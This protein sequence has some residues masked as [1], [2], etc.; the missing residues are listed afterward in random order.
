MASQTLD[1]KAFS[2]R[3]ILHLVHDHMGGPDGWAKT[4]EMA[5]S[6]GLS[7]NGMDKAAFDRH[8]RQCL[9]IR[10]SWIRRLTGCVER[11]MQN[12][13]QWR[14]TPDGELVVRAKLSG[15][16]ANGLEQMGDQAALLALQRLSA[17][18]KATG[19]TSANLMRREWQHG[20]A[21]R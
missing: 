18:Y 2:D 9:G 17:R 13:K 6:M 12:P 14:L 11:N 15:S 20:T 3:E 19:A 8:V 5:A 1:I 10:L 7:P 4:P 21:R 16:I